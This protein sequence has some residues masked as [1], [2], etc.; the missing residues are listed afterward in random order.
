MA[1]VD[2]KQVQ[3]LA[4]KYVTEYLRCKTDFDHFC[5]NYILI[6]V[7]G[8]DAKLKPYKKQVELV[9]LVE[10]KHWGVYRQYVSIQGLL[11]DFR[12]SS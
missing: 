1:K 8:K 4:D 5:K 7:P 2:Q 11:R 3:G 12:V 10:E 6:E 9:N